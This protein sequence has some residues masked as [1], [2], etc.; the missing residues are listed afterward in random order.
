M[1]RRERFVVNSVRDL[2]EKEREFILNLSNYGDPKVKDKKE[3]QKFSKQF[4]REFNAFLDW[5]TMRR[6]FTNL[7]R[8]NR[9]YGNNNKE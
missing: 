1:E 7:N 6:I 4:N 3:W 9:R 5:K 8:K 2:N